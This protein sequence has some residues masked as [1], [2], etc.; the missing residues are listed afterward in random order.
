MHCVWPGIMRRYVPGP[1]L[2]AGTN[3]LILLE[4]ERVPKDVSGARAIPDTTLL[5][6]NRHAPRSYTYLLL[7][8]VF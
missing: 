5:A 8:H 6:H 4:M 3:E 1:V 7:Y 2:R